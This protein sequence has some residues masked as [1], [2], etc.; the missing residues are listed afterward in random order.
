MAAVAFGIESMNEEGD[1]MNW[2]DLKDSRLVEEARAGERAA[3]DELVRRHEPKTYQQCLRILGSPEDAEDQAQG[4]FL[5]AYQALPGFRQDAM[6]STWL[7]SIARNACLMRLRKRHLPTVPLDSPIECK[8]GE[9][10]RDIPDPSANPAGRVMFGELQN[11]LANA[12]DDLAPLNREVF[13]LRT[14]RG[15]ST[16]DTANVLGLTSSAVRSRLHRA[17]RDLKHVMRRYL[18]EGRADSMVSLV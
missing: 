13:E 9:V 10:Q 11:V 16:E 12:M 6:F 8:D 4:V 2:A 17:R 14:L 18:D 7:Y 5:K 3:F 1:L 15:L